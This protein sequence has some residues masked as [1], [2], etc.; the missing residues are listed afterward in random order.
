MMLV[1]LISLVP[2]H[3]K[4]FPIRLEPVKS[5]VREEALFKIQFYL[6][7]GFKNYKNNLKKK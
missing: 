4:I 5:I 1:V 7:T 6:E 2:I 3:N